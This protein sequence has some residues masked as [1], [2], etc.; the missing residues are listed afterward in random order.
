LLFL[1]LI[2]LPA[3]HEDKIFYSLSLV[4]CEISIDHLL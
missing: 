3:F 2:L 1:F 4:S